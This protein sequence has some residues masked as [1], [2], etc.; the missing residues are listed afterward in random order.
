MESGAGSTDMRVPRVGGAPNGNTAGMSVRIT[1]NVWIPLADGTRLAARLWLPADAEANPVPAVLEYLPYRKDDGTAGQDAT[2]HPYFAEHG[3]AAVRVDIRGT[4]DSDGIITD[5]YTETEQ[6]D[7]VEVIAWIA[8]QPWCT[9]K[10]GMI[11]YS[12]GGFNGLQVAAH[13]PPELAAVATAYSTDDR[14]RD[15]CHYMGG[16]LLASDML[17]W[18]TS[19]RGYNALPPDPR[20]REDWRDVWRERLEKTPPFIEPWLS[21]QTWDAYWKQGSVCEDYSAIEAATLVVGGWADAYTNAVP[22]LLEHLACPA[23]GIIGPWAHILPYAGVPGPAIGFLAEC[24]RWFDRWLKGVDTG[25][26]DDPALRAWIQ[27]PVRPASYYAE[28]PGRWVGVAWPP[29]A[30]REARFVLG[31][32]EVRVASPQ[33]TGATAGVWC[34]N[35]Y[36]DELAEDQAP[37]DALSACFD[38]EPLGEELEVLGSPTVRLALS[39]DR[40]RALVAVRLCEVAPDGA[41]T[42][43]SW[44]MLNLTHRDGHEVPRDL[45]PGERYEVELA[46]NAI[47]QRFPR[48][49]RLRVAVSQAYWPHAWPSPEPV[50]LA[51]DVGACE[52]TLPLLEPGAA[53]LPRD[54]GPPEDGGGT[55]HLRDGSRRRERSYSAEAGVHAIRDEQGGPASLPNGTTYTA[56]AVDVYS[57]AED[58]PLSARITAR[59][60]EALSREGWNV[61]VVCEAMMI[62]SADEFIV[63]DSLTAYDDDEVV[64][65]SRRELRFPREGV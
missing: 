47:G 49:A 24:V 11:G 25:V 28:R 45:M 2:R 65:T 42:L 40:P 38:V 15:D 23:K 31:E 37:D 51:L 5:E 3:Y 64:F 63:D 26:D 58:D 54:F 53:A 16:C 7:A 8:A 21:H 36:D 32:S 46:L 61:R 39:A 52:L 30:A 20:F 29:R 9:G 55:V 43:V 12:W 44:G 34:A 4:G 17:K 13:R 41:S 56:S 33:H 35:G 62:A 10:V 27:E 57:I 59:R 19:M 48:G 50:T 22:R 14:Y 6:L 18:A 1:D 60:T